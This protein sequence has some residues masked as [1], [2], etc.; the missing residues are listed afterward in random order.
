MTA[1]LPRYVVPALLIAIALSAAFI[2]YDSDVSDATATASGTC[3]DDLA[4]QLEDGI[5]TINGTGA[6]TDYSLPSAPAPW[7][8]YRDA[9]ASVVFGDGVTTIGE[10]AFCDCGAL[11]SVE[12]PESLQSVGFFSFENCTSLGSVSVPGNVASIGAFAFWG[13]TS[14]SEIDVASGNMDYSSTDGILF[15]KDKKTLI[16]YPAG[17]T[18]SSYAVPDTVTSIEG[19]AFYG[20]AHLSSVTIQDSVGS[21]GIG[22]FS[23]CT[24]LSSVSMGDNVT[25]IGSGA[26]M[27]C[28]SLA[29]VTIPDGVTFLDDC[30]FQGCSSLTSV[31]VPDNVTA[32]GSLAFSGCSSLT[33][34]TLGS[35]LKYIGNYAFMDCPSLASVT[36][37]D[38]VTTLGQFVFS[39]C[40]SFTSILIPNGVE[41]IGENAFYGCTSLEAFYVSGANWCFSSSEGVLFDKERT[42]L[43]AYPLARAGDA[44]QIPNGITTIGEYA[45][46]GSALTSVTMPDSVTTIG[47]GAFAASH[48]ASLAMPFG[49]TAIG[50]YAFMDCSSLASISIPDSVT[51]LGDRAF[52]DCNNISS[53]TI[54]SGVTSIGA[55]AFYGCSSLTSVTI[56]N[57]VTSVGQYAFYG[58][59]SLLSV[60]V[61]SAVT[62]IGTDAFRDCDLIFEVVNLSS[63]PIA[64]GSPDYGGIAYGAMNVLSS[65]EESTVD[66]LD[67]RFIYG[68][69][70]TTP[71][72]LS[73]V[74]GD[75]S[76]VLPEEILGGDYAVYKGAFGGCGPFRE[77]IVPDSVISVAET[78]FEGFA[79]YDTDG[80]TVLE[81][82][83]ENLRG[84]MFVWTSGTEGYVKQ[85]RQDPGSGNYLLYAVLAGAA[86]AAIAVGA[87]IVIRRRA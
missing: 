4:W 27:D 69:S 20:C 82:T 47:D 14:L 2:L 61:G 84:S 48:L 79:F 83:A 76:L 28:S 63:L 54:G 55:D 18:G 68:R 52:K 30:M 36:I 40:T 59:G 64:R 19:F 5:L 10:E 70:G 56:P 80:T 60:T 57:G 81:P 71:Y 37:P 11:A 78:A 26:F 16:T 75:D 23:D 34:V 77:I 74:G 22:A 85:E 67:N 35:S 65:E 62:S 9:I 51:S 58:C 29:S 33:S 3:G 8:Q 86:A 13:C 66:T 17:R 42:I 45:F 1:R 49:L 7:Y 46:Y 38:S 53:L 24:S 73:Y 31:T 39:G 32:I 50:N 87:V 43:I 15:D 6:M 12:M 21:I 44:Y 41:S 25:S 72:L